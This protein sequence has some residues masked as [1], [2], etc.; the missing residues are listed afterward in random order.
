[1]VI[2]IMSFTVYENGPYRFHDSI[3]ITEMNQT[4]SYIYPIDQ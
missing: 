2:V 1:M 3:D 4:Y